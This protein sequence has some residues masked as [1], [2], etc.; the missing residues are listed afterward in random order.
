[1]LQGLVV[2]MPLLIEDGLMELKVT[3][4]KSPTE[5]VCEVVQGG[6]LKARKGVNVPELQIDCP[7]LTAKDVEDAEYLLGLEPPLEYIAVS[8]AQK[9][10]DLQVHLPLCLLPSAL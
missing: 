9:G 5:A 2:G 1:M 6:L 7:A 8:F 4:I 10:A 3:E